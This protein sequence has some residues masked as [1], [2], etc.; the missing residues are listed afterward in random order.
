MEVSTKKSDYQQL[1]WDFMG[2]AWRRKFWVLIPLAL[3][4]TASIYLYFTLPKIYQ[5]STLILVE[6]QKVP[7]S[8]VQ[9]AVSGTA[10]DRLSTIKQQI[11]SRTFLLKIID[12]YNLY[13]GESPS[14][15]KSI[16][17]KLLQK[18]HTP[19][20]SANKIERMRNNT[21][22]KVNRG[23][24]LESFSI[25]YMGKHPET[26][27][28]VTNE[29]A[30]LVIEENLRIRES[31]I[32]GATDFLEVELDNLSRELERQEKRVGDYKRAHM[33]ELPEQLDSNLRAL[34]R[35]QANLA[36]IQ[37][38]KKAAK[39]RITDLER[40]YEAVKIQQSQ[41]GS[42][43]LL[44]HTT[45]TLEPLPISPL[46]K[47]LNRS[48]ETLSNLLME[49]N[50]NYPD[51]VMLRREI[52]DLEKQIKASNTNSRTA[53]PKNTQ[54]TPRGTEKKHS[55]DTNI[56]AGP[57]STLLQ[58]IREANDELKD[59][60][61][62][63]K[64]VLRQIQMYELRVEN[65]PKRE[66]EM[67]IIQ[68]DYDNVSSSYQ[69]LLAKK[70]NAKISENLEKRQ[71]GEQFRVIDTANLPDKPV[72]PNKLMV[73][74]IGSV[75]GLGLGIGLAFIREQLD[76]SIRKA[77]EVERITSVLVLAIIPDFETE[78]KKSEKAASRKVVDIEQFSGRKR[79][80]RQSGG[81]K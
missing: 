41:L 7:Q 49:Y 11:L 67:V 76:N 36:A 56:G 60:G 6:G 40:M 45:A 43:I 29:L 80:L 51:V 77:E 70:L 79:Y 20:S 33:G 5:S 58:Q 23:K 68:R 17:D 48:R 63:E 18:E 53:L 19:I 3:G 81:K 2:I 22:L 50:D 75:L 64:K 27:M 31:F 15:L 30:S 14:L 42:E 38:A 47:R 34:D 65:T 4:I 46:Q 73:M 72:K 54:E 16:L 1:I 39:D 28:N 71:K 21:E 62:K 13:E 55:G 61:E 12:K 35:F 32:E 44:D 37:I 52:N 78:L 74:L 57:L 10:Q 69:A 9:S 8:V 24:K 59:I 25:S 26:V 66:Q